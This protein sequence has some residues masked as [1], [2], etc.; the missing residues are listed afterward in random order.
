M[1]TKNARKLSW[2]DM[3]DVLRYKCKEIDEDEFL[4]TVSSMQTS[5]FEKKEIQVT[6]ETIRDNGFC[7]GGPFDRM[8]DSTSYKSDGDPNRRGL[9]IQRDKFLQ[10]VEN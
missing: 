3:R 6:K 4:V 7:N 9:V 10:E 1:K 8:F 2:S 5:L